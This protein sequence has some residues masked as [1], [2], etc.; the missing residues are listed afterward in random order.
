MEKEK[1][2]KGRKRCRS[3]NAWAANCAKKARNEVIIT[4][5]LS[6][7]LSQFA[8]I[9]FYVFIKIHLCPVIK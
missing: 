4:A 2:K 3:E 7:L 1:P 9:I 8:I 6:K 5:K